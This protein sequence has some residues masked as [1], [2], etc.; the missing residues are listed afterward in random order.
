MSIF[1][2]STKIPLLVEKAFLQNL[3][4]RDLAREDV[5][6]KDICDTNLELFGAKGSEERR[7][8]Q[9]Y[10]NNL[11]RRTVRS[12]AQL[13]DKFKVHHGVA[14]TRLLRLGARCPDSVATPSAD[15]TPVR[16]PTPPPIK[17]EEEPEEANKTA[18]LYSRLLYY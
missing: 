9:F 7:N 17:A 3:E 10:H 12:Y 13:L 8:L 6:L 4:S 15:S 11:K 14:T 18:C 5:Q 1:E 16:S 2:G